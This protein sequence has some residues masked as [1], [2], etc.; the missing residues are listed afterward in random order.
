MRE[1]LVN[2]CDTFNY[3]YGAHSLYSYPARM[4]WDKVIAVVT[5]KIAIS[6]HLGTRAARKH[7]QSVEISDQL[8]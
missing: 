2:T 8:A 3:H 7:N 1:E 4:R 5:T 6:R